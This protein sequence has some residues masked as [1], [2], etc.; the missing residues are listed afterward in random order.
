MIFADEFRYLG[1]L[2]LAPHERAVRARQVIP[3]RGRR[4]RTQARIQG[5]E[6]QA[7]RFRQRCDCVTIFGFVFDSLWRKSEKPNEIAADHHGEREF[8]RRSRSE[9]TRIRRRRRGAQPNGQR[10]AGLDVFERHVE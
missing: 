7:R 10:V 5:D 1:D 4:L 3:G 2:D 6:R 9:R 8:T